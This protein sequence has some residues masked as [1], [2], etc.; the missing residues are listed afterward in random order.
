[1]SPRYCDRF[2]HNDNE[3]AI[4]LRDSTCKELLKDLNRFPQ[5]GKKVQQLIL[6]D[7]YDIWEDPDE[8]PQFY[9]SPGGFI[10]A[11]VKLCPNLMDLQLLLDEIA[12]LAEL[13]N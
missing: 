4:R 6:C 10:K 2:F 1:M 7:E 12:C 11:I 9:N 13:I 8:K 3:I 5:F